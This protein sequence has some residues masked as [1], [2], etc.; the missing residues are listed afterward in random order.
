M[1]TGAGE[2]VAMFSSM[3]IRNYRLFWTG[4][5]V[6]NVGTW[7]ARVAQDLSLIHI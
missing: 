4:G 2:K 5:F 1:T 7:M 3:K 6:S